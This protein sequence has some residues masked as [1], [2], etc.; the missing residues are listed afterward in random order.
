MRALAIRP[1]TADDY[2]P[3]RDVVMAAPRGEPGKPANQGTARRFDAVAALHNQRGE[4]ASPNLA[5]FRCAPRP[6]GQ[7]VIELLEKHPRSTQ[8]FIPM[9]ARRF[10]VVVALGGE[11]PD[12]TTLAAFEASGAQGVSYHPGVWHHPM[13]ALDA[14]TDFS[15]LVWED[16]S[17]DD[18][19][20]VPLAASERWAL[21]IAARV[22]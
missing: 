20:V 2:S 14:P 15:V 22:G 3:H 16:G 18:C 8:V 17:D 9:N 6:P 13:I 19:V 7:L 12:L 1:L 4:R 10:L 5:V 11:R 21:S